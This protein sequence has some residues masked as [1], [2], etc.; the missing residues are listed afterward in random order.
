MMGRF[1][2]GKFSNISREYLM[3]VNISKIEKFYATPYE[4][5]RNYEYL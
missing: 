2:L 3:F 1:T 5:E 4:W